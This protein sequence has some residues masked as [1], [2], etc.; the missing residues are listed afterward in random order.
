MN[1]TSASLTSIACPAVGFCVAVDN[2]DSAYIYSNGQWS[3]PTSLS[4]TPGSQLFNVSCA[5]ST[6]CMAAGD[7]NIYLFN[8][9]SWQVSHI[10]A[11][12]F[13]PPFWSISCPTTAFCAANGG[14]GDLATYNGVQ[15][16]VS[17]GFSYGSQTFSPNNHIAPND[18]ISCSSSSFCIGVS[19]LYP[20]QHARLDRYNGATWSAAVSTSIL[21]TNSA[22][23]CPVPSSCIVTV[24]GGAFVYNGTSWSQDHIVDS[25]PID[26]ISC[27][28]SNFCTATDVAGNAVMYNGTSWTSSFNLELGYRVAVSCA[29]VDFCVAGGSNGSFSI[30]QPTKQTPANIGVSG[31]EGSSGSGQ[32]L[33]E[34]ATVLAPGP[35]EYQVRPRFMYLSGDGSNFVKNLTWSKW[36]IS[37]AAGHGDIEPQGTPIPVTIDLKQPSHGVFTLLLERIAGQTPRAFPLGPGGWQFTGT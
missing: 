31:T 12:G 27:V 16:S 20:T 6:F 28:T 10:F 8:G 19:D 35:P 1:L 24:N 2:S 21:L 23:S 32:T 33:P 7:T 22:A 37:G 5:S 4:A 3:A 29:S 13:A 14:N 17:T 15:W 26:S 9:T 36:G 18:E 11:L 30:W 25:S 34:A